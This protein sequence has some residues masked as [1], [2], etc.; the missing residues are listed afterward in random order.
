MGY[1]CSDYHV[2]NGNGDQIALIDHNK[3]ARY[4][5]HDISL[6][7]NKL[8][9]ALRSKLGVVPGDRI[10]ILLPQSIETGISHLSAFKL[11]AIS[12]PLFILF[13][14]DALEYRLSDSG[15]KVLITNSECLSKISAIRDRLPELQHIIVTGTD[16][17]NDLDLSDTVIEYHS[18]ESLVHSGN[19][20]FECVTTKCDDPALIIYT[21]G[22][23]GSP[24]GCLHAHRVLLG[25]L[26][27]IETPHNFLP[28][29]GDIFWTPADWAW[30]GGLLDALLPSWYYGI[31]IVAHR[32]RKFDVL[33]AF[34]IM[35][36]YNVTS[37]F[38]P[39]TALKMMK[40]VYD[41]SGEEDRCKMEHKLRSIG[42]GGESLGDSLHEWATNTFGTDINEFYGQTECNL[43]VSNA[44]GVF[45]AKPKSMGKAV[46]GHIV[47]VVDDDG[48][49]CEVNEVGNVAVKYPDP[50]M[51]LKYWNNPT[52][53]AE[54]FVSSKETEGE[55]TTHWLVTGDLAR[56]DED[57]YLFYDSRDDDVISM[58]GYRIGPVPIERACMKHPDVVNCAVI[59]I[60]DEVKGEVIKVFIVL[61][62]GC[63]ERDGLMTEI[64]ELVRKSEGHIYVPKMIEIVQELP[65]TITGKVQRNVLRD[66]ECERQQ[67]K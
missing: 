23:T 8:S 3:S 59:G 66:K 27:G 26:P 9:N 58:G 49:V 50:V 31:P 45:D 21:S 33:E 41:T 56:K 51:F 2:A 63:I 24:K 16:S 7:S 13:G 28:Q 62:E 43:I 30:I 46:P 25:H 65:M 19:S 44:A 60:P 4:T 18:F 54:K 35:K 29:K 64:Q 37:S 12:L 22:T 6:L 61:N 1:E 47:E 14:D 34:D 36:Q 32:A 42:S 67:K 17:L 10:S 5:F 48:R 39:P 55:A 53:T 52:K 40:M 11:G 38:L 20:E 15:T 57:G